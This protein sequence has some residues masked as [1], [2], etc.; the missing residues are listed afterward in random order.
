[1]RAVER[2]HF[3][4]ELGDP[5]LLDRLKGPPEWEKALRAAHEA[6]AAARYPEAE[7]VLDERVVAARGSSGTA[8]DRYLPMTLGLIG[9]CRF[10]QGQA[11]EAVAVFRQALEI[12]ERTGNRI[13]AAMARLMLLPQQVN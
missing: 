1:M 5:S 9:Q 8:V 3:K 6:I 11:T 12:C 4:H 7:A 10:H 2:W 13:A